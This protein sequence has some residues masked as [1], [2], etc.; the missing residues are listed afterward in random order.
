MDIRSKKGSVAVYAFLSLTVLIALLFALYLGVSA[1]HR[2]QIKSA[3]AIKEEVLKYAEENDIEIIENPDE[4]YLYEKYQYQKKGSDE[5]VYIPQEDKIYKFTA[6][7]RYLNEEIF[8][9]GV[10]G[11]NLA[12]GDTVIFDPTIGV[13]NTSLLRYT[14]P[15]GSARKNAN[16][17]GN[18]SASQLIEAKSSH[19][20]WKVLAKSGS[21]ITLVSA[22]PIQTSNNTDFSLANGRG[23]LYAE[24]QLNL[25]CGVFGHSP[26]VDKT[27]TVNYQIGSPEVSGE[28]QNKQLTNVGARSLSLAEVETILSQSPTS[29]ETSH[30]A[31]L[32]IPTLEGSNDDGRCSLLR[33]LKTTF[34]TYYSVSSTSFSSPL[35]PTIFASGGFWLSGRQVNAGIPSHAANVASINADILS[36]E[37]LFEGGKNGADM[38]TVSRGLRPVVLLKSNARFEEGDIPG[39]WTVVQE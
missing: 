34:S 31:S 17:S 12:L 19:N 21:Q 1:R 14:S 2:S 30:N 25:A 7:A 18:G 11:S 10:V 38:Y 8:L 32:Y 29:T 24:E 6:T 33:K 20:Q 36:S 13:T 35:T 22:N 4:I 15:I 26:V 28:I 23:Y 9:S 39:N 5:Y 3:Q 16:V 27:M 37:T